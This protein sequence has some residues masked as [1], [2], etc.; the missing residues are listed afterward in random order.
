MWSFGWSESPSCN[1]RTGPEA[2]LFS[3]L[4]RCRNKQCVEESLSNYSIE[5][6]SRSRMLF[7]EDDA[8]TLCC[9]EHLAAA[10]GLPQGLR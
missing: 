8:G 9:S 10:R 2:N 4:L 1:R 7:R 5:A 3:L 6:L